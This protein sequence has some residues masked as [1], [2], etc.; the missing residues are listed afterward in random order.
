MLEIARA[1]YMQVVEG[2]VTQRIL[3]ILGRAPV[4]TLTGTQPVSITCDLVKKAA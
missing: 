3:M 1:V 4:T 2:L